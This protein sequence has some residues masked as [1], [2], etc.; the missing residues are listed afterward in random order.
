MH[1]VNH[2]GVRK[3]MGFDGGI[4]ITESVI[5]GVVIAAILVLIAVWLSRDLKKIP[6]GK[7]ASRGPL[8]V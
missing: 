1:D 4:F 7:P 3:I 8:P 5:W 2:L 6:K